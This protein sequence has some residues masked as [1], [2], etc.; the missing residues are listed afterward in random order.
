M[1]SPGHRRR[2]RL[3]PDPRTPKLRGNREI[4]D[5]M[6]VA[7]WIPHTSDQRRGPPFVVLQDELHPVVL[8]EN[9]LQ[10]L[11][12][13]RPQPAIKLRVAKP[14]TYPMPIRAHHRAYVKPIRVA[15]SRFR[16]HHTRR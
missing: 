6:L 4:G 9:M 11:F 12:I 2:D 13:D 3:T 5:R 8:R 1:P 10:P 15:L 16:V 14:T 7:R